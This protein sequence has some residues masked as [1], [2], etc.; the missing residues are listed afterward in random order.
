MTNSTGI[1]TLGP[2]F[3]GVA[4]LEGK[5][6]SAIDI[7]EA[8][9]KEIAIVGAG[10]AGLMT[11][12]VLHQSGM[13]NIKIIEASQRLGGRVH[14][15][16]LS[17]G[18]FDYSYQE[19]GPM[20]FPN[21]ITVGND[22]LNITDHQLVFQ[23]AEEMNKLNN[24]ASNWSVDFIPWYQ[25]S[26]N[27]LYYY[28]GIKL[29]TGLPPTVSQVAGNSSLAITLEDDA[30]TTALSDTLVSLSHQLEVKDTKA[31]MNDPG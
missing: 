19:M 29:D 20:R 30:S 21:T 7:A 31:N 15:E 16:Y 5:N 17:G 1:D 4:L 25:S 11:Y 3:D 13:E 8:K 24:H 23:L 26:S 9:S 14:T 28:D 18:P 6:L 10:M 27:G 2:W 22:T 12:L